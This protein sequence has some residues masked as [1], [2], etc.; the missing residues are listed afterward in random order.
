MAIKL[1]LLFLVSA[2]FAYQLEYSTSFLEGRTSIKIE[3]YRKPIIQMYWIR[4]EKGGYMVSGII[5]FQKEN[6]RFLTDIPFEEVKKLVRKNYGFIEYNL[7]VK[8]INAIVEVNEE[9][10]LYK[11]LNFNVNP[12]VTTDLYKLNTYIKNKLL[13]L[14]KE[15]TEFRKKYE[16]M[17]KILKDIP[18]EKRR[19]EI[20][21]ELSK[22][23]KVEIKDWLSEDKLPKKLFLV[24]QGYYEDTKIFKLFPVKLS[25]KKEKS[26]EIAFI[27]KGKEFVEVGIK[28]FPTAYKE[29]QAI[30]IDLL[31]LNP[32]Q[33]NLKGC[34]HAYI[35]VYPHYGK[36]TYYGNYELGLLN[37]KKGFYLIL[38][39]F[40][41][42]DVYKI[43]LRLDV[44]C[45][46][47]PRKSISLLNPFKGD[48][49]RLHTAISLN[50]SHKAFLKS[51]GLE[52]VKIETRFVSP[53]G[54]KSE[55]FIVNLP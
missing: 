31:T 9:P 3:L 19:R 50:Y 46:N 8:S 35:G 7:P 48:K 5:P 27:R 4:L 11:P 30:A 51:V 33:V 13:R 38:R 10:I 55:P 49:S 43:Y 28:F 20:I 12:T 18:E 22:L 37:Y 36:N 17:N 32:T 26:M 6:C 54:Y 34:K 24:C 2:L 16:E 42:Q 40:E 14:L 45:S 39:S 47:K 25:V 21:R 29:Y 52:R 15:D 1:F 53:N 23:I 41:P 44:Y